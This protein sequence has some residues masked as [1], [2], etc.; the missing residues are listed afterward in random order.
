MKGLKSIKKRTKLLPQLQPI[1][2][3]NFCKIKNE[4]IYTD[5]KLFSKIN[6]KKN[7]LN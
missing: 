1:S 3:I 4:K 6:K 5:K 7:K 2:Y